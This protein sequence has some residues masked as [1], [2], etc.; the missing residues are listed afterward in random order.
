MVSSSKAANWATA[1]SC[2]DL[3]ISP[4]K[5]LYGGSASSLV[6]FESWCNRTHHLNGKQRETFRMQFIL[7]AYKSLTYRHRNDHLNRKSANRHKCNFW[8]QRVIESQ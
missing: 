3:I 2:A 7:G 8:Q 1:K 4:A 6:P 5:V